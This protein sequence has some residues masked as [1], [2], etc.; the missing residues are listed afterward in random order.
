MK[1]VLHILF[2][3]V[4][5]LGMIG[6]A[7]ATASAHS[8]NNPGETVAYT[9]ISG[10]LYRGD[11][12]D[13]REA[14]VSESCHGNMTLNAEIVSNYHTEDQVAVYGVHAGKPISLS[15]NLP[16][17]AT[18]VEDYE[19][20]L[21]TDTVRFSLGASVRRGAIAV[22]KRVGE[23]SQF[24]HVATATHVWGTG[25]TLPDA[26][27]TPSAEDVMAGMTLRVCVLY[28]T[29][30]AGGY[31]RYT[32]I[33]EFR[34]VSA[35][36]LVLIQPLHTTE[37]EAAFQAEYG[38]AWRI[39]SIGDT[40]AD[41]S[42]TT[43]GFT[44]RDFGETGT[45]IEVSHNGAPYESVRD[46]QVYRAV[47]QY[48]I[49]VTRPHQ[50][51]K[52]TTV[53]IVPNIGESA[54]F[55]FLDGTPISSST[56]IFDPNSDIPVY[57][58]EAVLRLADTSPFPH[59]RG[60]LSR[61]TEDGTQTDI[62]TVDGSLCRVVRITE[63]GQYLL[64]LTNGDDGLPGTH[65]RFHLIFRI[66]SEADP[67]SY[68]QHLIESDQSLSNLTALHYEVS[69]QS[70]GLGVLRVAFA[71]SRYDE[72]VKFA[73]ESEKKHITETETGFFYRGQAFPTQRA[74]L[75][76]LNRAARAAVTLAVYDP[77]QNYN[78]ME[79]VADI[80]QIISDEDLYLFASTTERELSCSE[81]PILSRNHVF[82]HVPHQAERI[83]ATCAK[84]GETV[85]LVLGSRSYL[86]LHHGTWTIREYADS[87]SSAPVG[88]SYE[89]VVQA[90]NE[91]AYSVE[92]EG[93][94]VWNASGTYSAPLTISDFFHPYDR[95]G[96]VILTNSYGERT[97][98]A[99]SH[100]SELRLMR[101]CWT[102][103]FCD[104]LGNTITL[105]VNGDG[106]PLAEADYIG[107]TYQ[108]Q[109]DMHRSIAVDSAEMTRVSHTSPP[110]SA[111][112]SAVSESETDTLKKTDGSPCGC[113][114]L[115][116]GLSCM[117]I[118]VG[119]A[120]CLVKRKETNAS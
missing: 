90:V 84:C 10:H 103:E 120:C 43:G 21:Y 20:Y 44:I 48:R 63:P 24:E 108:I 3:F 1:H 50:G 87:A 119:I 9:S 45:R 27:Y 106:T 47:G 62:G 104:S 88:T 110:D 93:Q 74:L 46:E 11:R 60:T 92:L 17:Q 72:A 19:T 66:V 81:T 96:V 89:V 26:F 41:G 4:I 100:L 77:T 105:T 49:L 69:I 56:R 29:H 28:A 112:S 116:N 55:Y 99:L 107:S 16:M 25:S 82:V 98:L 64:Q 101:G 68:N 57:L 22:F 13:S 91:I 8:R 54:E 70:R 40:L 94:T 53:Y 5:A 111:S 51:S 37:E 95:E 30:D 80:D 58:G 31:T 86:Q 102:V 71:L 38:E 6:A 39:L 109:K 78:C 85:Q 61:Q 32:E 42:M 7:I 52:M 75:D 35:H 33:Y 113:T 59:L 97:V 12:Y 36:D 65:Y 83:T 23:E 15:Y 114:A 79:T 14:T 73:L 18:L 67:I 2:F 117:M 34:L 118:S 115:T 76:A